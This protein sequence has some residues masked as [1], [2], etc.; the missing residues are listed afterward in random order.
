MSLAKFIPIILPH[1]PIGGGIGGPSVPLLGHGAFIIVDSTGNASFYEYGH[2]DPDP[3]I[4]PY[5]ITHNSSGNN[6]NVRG[7][8]IDGTMQY[9]S[10]GNITAS[11]LQNALD[12]V[13]GNPSLYPNDPGEVF[14]TPFNITDTQ[15]NKISS[16]L[17]DF[18]YDVN[19]GDNDNHSK[20][21]V[22]I[23]DNIVIPFM[24]A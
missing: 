6:T 15:Y 4:E 13:F 14:A 20:E 9:D 16:A 21:M 3:N 11:S 23:V 2:F 10:S 8:G 22:N 19:S 12:Q 17:G 5:V 24:V 18:I 7:I 1:E